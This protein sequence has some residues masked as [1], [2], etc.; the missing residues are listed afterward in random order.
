VAFCLCCLFSFSFF[1]PR[2]QSHHRGYSAVI[3]GVRPTAHFAFSLHFRLVCFIYLFIYLIFISRYG[4]TFVIGP[5]PPSS[6]L[7]ILHPFGL[8]LADRAPA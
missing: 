2:L 1:L 4:F 7:I 6:P 5:P 8:S 3:G